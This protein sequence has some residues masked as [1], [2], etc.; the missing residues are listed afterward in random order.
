[1]WKKRDLSFFKCKREGEKISMYP[2]WLNFDENKNE[3]YIIP[4]WGN[5]VRR[6]FNVALTLGAKKIALSLSKEV[7]KNVSCSFFA[8]NRYEH[9]KKVSLEVSRDIRFPKAS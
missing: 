9:C 7:I 4:K 3:F 1:M 6:I 2:F 5:L 8:P